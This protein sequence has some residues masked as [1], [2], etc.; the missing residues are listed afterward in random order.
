MI[1]SV[2]SCLSIR[3]EAYSDVVYPAET[4]QKQVHA[5]Q[6]GD[7]SYHVTA[8]VIE[9]MRGQWE[10][11]WVLDF[12][13]RVY[14]MDPVP[15]WVHEGMFVTADVD[16]FFDSSA[17]ASTKHLSCA[18]TLRYRWQIDHITRVVMPY[19][20]LV[21]VDDEQWGRIGNPTRQELSTVERTDFREDAM[22]MRAPDAQDIS[23]VLECRL[24]STGDSVR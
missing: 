21:E 1:W 5:M 23:Y 22:K 18:D 14:R 15:P 19:V 8:E 9:I 10:T 12:G 16:L 13:L 24:L 3:F 7:R 2:A 17:F 4:L 6:D 20:P 11:S